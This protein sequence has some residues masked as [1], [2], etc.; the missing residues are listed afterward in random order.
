MEARLGQMEQRLNELFGKVD[1]I[2]QEH[3]EA[4]ASTAI[5]MG[6]IAE[7]SLETPVVA[8]GQYVQQ[9]RDCRHEA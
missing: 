4:N 1:T 6:Q 2:F 7:G 8:C 5:K 3:A 9:G